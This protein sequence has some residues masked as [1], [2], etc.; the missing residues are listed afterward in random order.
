MPRPSWASYFLGIAEAVGPGPAGR[1]DCTRR[2]VG[3]VIT[4]DNRI[5]SCG[6]NGAPAGEGSCLAGDCPRGVHHEVYRYT[7]PPYEQALPSYYGA[8]M[9]GCACSPGQKW[10]CPDAVPPSSSYDTGPGG[11]I[12]VHA[13]FNACLYAGAEARGGTIWIAARSGL[14]G[15]VS[16]EPCDGC[17]RAIKAAGIT[18]ACWRKADG[19]KG[20]WSK[21]G[22]PGW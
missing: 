16:A 17:W 5:V 8:V 13:E 22:T 15:I 2:K 9:S 11:C 3:A 19:S 7:L 10:P 18:G 12:A 21:D 20:T 6:Y 1:A 4:R 14:G